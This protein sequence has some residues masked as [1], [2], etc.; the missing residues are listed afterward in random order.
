MKYESRTLRCSECGMTLVDSLPA[1]ETAAEPDG[2]NFVELT[3]F[4]NVS[5][6]EMVNDL[7]E[8]NDIRAVLRGEIDPIGVVRGAAP[9]TLL[10]EERD[11]PRGREMDETYFAGEVIEA[12]PGD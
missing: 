4:S 9:T 8:K 3:R 2:F 6:A 12:N 5:Q 7:L 1:R 11:L 10:V